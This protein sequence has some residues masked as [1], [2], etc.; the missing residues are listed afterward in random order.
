LDSNFLEIARCETI[1]KRFFQEKL[2]TTQQ[3][4][5]VVN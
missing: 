4:Q 5:S 1:N 2:F 3:R